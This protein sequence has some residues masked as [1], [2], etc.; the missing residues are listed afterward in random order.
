MRGYKVFS[1]TSNPKLAQDIARALDMPLSSAKVSKFSDGEISVQISESVRGRDVFIVQPTCAPA[2]D[3]F[4]ELLIMTD[5]LRR[6]SASSITAVMPYFGY[7]RQD[8]KAAP[9]VPIT[10]KLVADLIEKAGVDRVVTMDLHAGQIQGF[11]DIPVDNLYGAMLFTN[12]LKNKN[13]QSPIIASPDIG[14]VARARYFAQK[15]GVDMVIVD[16]K[17]EKANES[18]VM[19][20]IG[21]VEGKDVILVDDMVD[22]AGTM[23]KAA[24]VLKEKGA[25]SVMACATHPVLSGPAYDRI[26]DSELDEL[27]VSDTIPLSKACQECEKI[28]LLSVAPIFGEVIRRVYHNES[29]NS[30]FS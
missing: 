19:N 25:N 17:R 1:G 3:N 28:K 10:A 26:K 18:E 4:M 2:N 5:A 14:G 21:N 9:R 7:A 13:L 30:L 23:V 20:I 8:R 29:V 12:Y 22:T 24:K 27:V 16:K 15:L 11:F 6:S